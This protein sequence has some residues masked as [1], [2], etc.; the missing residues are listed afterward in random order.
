MPPHWSIARVKDHARIINGYPFDSKLF[1]ADTGY[2]LVRIRDISSSETVVRYDGDWIP[3][4]A[5][6]TGDI[7]VGMD[8]EFNIARWSGGDALLN[9]RVC[10]IRT[11]ENIDPGYLYY[12]L[13]APL[14]LI[15]EFT[16]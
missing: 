15:N 2:P 9:Q 7:L 10:C 5:I 3:E 16:Y 8:G 1:A 12:A 14:R 6:S 4:A 11:T 13:P